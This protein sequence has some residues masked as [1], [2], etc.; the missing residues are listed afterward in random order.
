MKKQILIWAFMLIGS[1]PMQAQ[2]WFDLSAKGGWGPNFLFHENI[3]DD[4][5]VKHKFSSAPMFGGKLGLNFGDRHAINLDVT[6]S[7]F[8]QNFERTG[9]GAFGLTYIDTYPDVSFSSLNLSLLY[10]KIDRGRYLEIGPSMMRISGEDRFNESNIGAVFGF[11]R[12]LAGNDRFAVNIGM[13][14]N[15]VIADINSPAAQSQHYP[16]S[17]IYDQYK[18]AHPLTMAIYLEVDW[19][20]GM[21]GTSSCYKRR[22]FVFF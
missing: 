9:D 12:S 13:R 22:K 18:G 14:F 20:V 3:F 17:E 16:G 10:R 1:L 21:W 5:T 8:K 15:Y 2:F 11:G 4:A 6:F 19:A 7:T